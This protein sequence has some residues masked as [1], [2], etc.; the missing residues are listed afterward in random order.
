MPLVHV[1]VVVDTCCM[2]ICACIYAYT[3][4]RVRARL[5]LQNIFSCMLV[6][7]RIH[8]FMHLMW[9]A[10]FFLLFFN[11]TTPFS[12]PHHSYQEAET[13]CV[14]GKNMVTFIRVSNCSGPEHKNN[15]STVACGMYF[16]I[17][18]VYVV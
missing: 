18:G 10:A 15:P 17:V 13:R 16:A 11:L 6:R 3:H 12:L 8:L 4:A 9:S 5:R 2:Y 1:C 14:E 7:A